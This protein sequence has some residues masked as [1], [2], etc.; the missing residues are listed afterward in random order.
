MGKITIIYE[1]KIAD[2][3]IIV[4]QTEFITV[5]NRGSMEGCGYICK[6][7]LIDSNSR[8]LYHIHEQS[9]FYF[10][11]KD[12]SLALVKPSVLSLC[13]YENISWEF[14]C[15]IIYITLTCGNPTALIYTIGTIAHNEELRSV[16]I[17]MIGTSNSIIMV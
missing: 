4:N 12:N 2:N 1:V 8:G 6:I 14:K 11:L 3:K 16:H 13:I 7:I 9:C 17:E 5:V 15:T 10:P